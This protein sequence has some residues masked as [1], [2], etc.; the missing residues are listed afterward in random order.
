MGKL[1]NNGLSGPLPSEMGLLTNLEELLMA[2]S[3]MG[4][5][6]I[7]EEFWNMSSAIFIDINGAGL[8]GTISTNI[9]RMTNMK[10]LKAARNSFNGTLPSEIGLLDDLLLLHI[11]VNP[12]LGGTV[13]LEVCLLRGP[14]NLQFL[15]ADCAGSVPRIGRTFGCC[16]GCC[17]EYGQ[18][19]R[20]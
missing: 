1:T 7:P 5:S 3:N 17:D 11:H 14:E 9:G 19:Q 2:G 15:N 20:Q 16:T 4:G 8:E 10:G 12:F 13:P 18:C 6:T